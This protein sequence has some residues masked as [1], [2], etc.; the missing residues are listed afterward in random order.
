MR[1]LRLCNFSAYGRLNHRLCSGCGMR[2]CDPE[3]KAEAHEK[4]NGCREL[5]CISKNDHT[6]CSG[7]NRYVCSPNDQYEKF[8]HR[9]NWRGEYFCVD[10]RE[11]EEEKPEP[12]TSPEPVLPPDEDNEP[13]NENLCPGGC[14]Q[15]VV[16]GKCDAYGEN[17]CGMYTCQIAYCSYLIPG[18]EKCGMHHERTCT[19]STTPVTYCQYCKM[20]LENPASFNHEDCAECGRCSFDHEENCPNKL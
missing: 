15:S 10:Y 11:E 3:Y 16:H 9:V 6:R 20:C 2:K 5:L 8:N 14:G 4:C 13:E 17:S 12:E 18:G 7:C 1:G 19:S